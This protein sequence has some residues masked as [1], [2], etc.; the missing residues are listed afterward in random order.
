[1]F[2]SHDQPGKTNLT[3]NRHGARYDYSD[4]RNGFVLD[5]IHRMVL[6]RQLPDIGF[7]FRLRDNPD[8]A[9]NYSMT[10]VDDYITLQDALAY[11]ALYPFSLKVERSKSRHGPSSL[12][13]SPLENPS[14]PIF[15]DGTQWQFKKVGQKERNKIYDEVILP[16]LMD[17]DTRNNGFDTLTIFSSQDPNVQQGRVAT[18]PGVANILATPLSFDSREVYVVKKDGESLDE[19]AR[20][21]QLTKQEILNYRSQVQAERGG[22]RIDDRELNERTYDP[23]NLEEGNMIFLP[24]PS[25]L[26][27]MPAMKV[28]MDPDQDDDIFQRY[29]INANSTEISV[30][31]VTRPREI[32][33]ERRIVSPGL[34]DNVDYDDWRNNVFSTNDILEARTTGDL[35]GFIDV[36]NTPLDRDWE[37]TEL[38]HTPAR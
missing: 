32:A 19:I 10:A 17:P 3:V 36:I 18:A 13:G 29:G 9:Q 38:Q 28:E 5:F 15:N 4:A 22:V 2:P 8:L 23:E 30:N 26:T 7:R 6:V 37:T 25:Y 33:E 31:L 24:T 1:M 27:R 20:K 11:C 35:N 34:T 16:Y 14:N 12:R 21:N